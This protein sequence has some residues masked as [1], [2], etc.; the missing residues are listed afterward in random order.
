MGLRWL[1]L[2]RAFALIWA[3]AG[4]GWG[5]EAPANLAAW[6]ARRAACLAHAARY[7][8]PHGALARLARGEALGDPAPFAELTDAVA[9]RQDMSEF[10]VVTLLRLSL[11][12]P[13]AL[14]TA[15]AE[16]IEAALLG[17][18]YWIDEPGR[19]GM[20]LWT[21]N[22]VLGFAAAEL[23]AGERWPE[24]V[25]ANSG[26]R[27]REHAAKARAR[28]LRWS[29]ERLRY[30]FSE[31]LSPVYLALHVEPLV[32]LTDHARDADV[33]RRAA[34][35]LDLVLFDLARLPQRGH[36]GLTAGRT[37]DEFCLEP[38]R[39]G[40]AD[41]I[42]LLQG[43]RGGFRDGADREAVA[44]SSSRYRL[45]W[46]LAAIAVDTPPPHVERLRVG[47][48]P[49]EGPAE[50]IGFEDEDDGVFWWQQGAYAHPRVVPLSQRMVAAHGLGGRPEFA[51]LSL[52]APAEALSTLSRALGRVSRGPL[53]CGANL[54]V[55]HGPDALLSSV[56]DF[57]PG[58]LG[59]Q[60]HAWQ[61]TLDR[62]A[63][64]FSNAPGPWN[65]P[66]PG[67]WAGSTHLPR[68]IQVRDV[69]VALYRPGIAQRLAF[70]R[71]THAYVPRAGFDE[72]REVDGWVCARKGSGYLA[73]RSARPTRWRGEQ[74]LVADGAQ[75]AWV[76][77]VGS[78]AEDGS[79]ARFVA[80]IAGARF[81]ARGVDRFGLGPVAVSYDA[82]GLGELAVGW[83]GP[84]T[85]NG[86]P[87]PP[88]AHPRFAT[89]YVDAPWP[90]EQLELRHEGYRLSLSPD[91]RSGD[92]L[93]PRF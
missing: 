28:F 37:Y 69:L 93:E 11:G 58:T 89:P 43:S 19:D 90:A 13:E 34:T 91:A 12:Y 6:D 44:L 10:R 9:A 30:G 7:G 82:P 77:Q 40:V 49:E 73:L 4:L 32:A 16:R 2:L 41:V 72:L 21:E 35:V 68:V 79:F 53:L 64:V 78:A 20:H 25:F 17:F 85:L 61:A 24:R 8:G 29:R 71:E 1:S 65:R 57:R 15:L 51:P 50:G 56:Q 52:D 48:T 87:L 14:P 74:E 75:N 38:Q 60:V 55:F 36:F 66:G 42:E 26:L 84:A 45:P 31:W 62:E 22:H 67:A 23:L 3:L 80:G 5:Q 33:R 86:E 63:F 92:G 81:S 70:P 83:T 39:H 76:C 54:T 46:V 88:P 27:G 47:L 18:R 59:F